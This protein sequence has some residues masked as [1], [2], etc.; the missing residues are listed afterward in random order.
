MVQRSSNLKTQK[1]DFFEKRPPPLNLI[2]GTKPELNP[3]IFCI[4]YKRFSVDF[5]VFVLNLRSE[6]ENIKNDQFMEKIV[7]L[8]KKNIENVQKFQDFLHIH[9]KGMI[10]IHL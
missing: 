5:C 7:H 6:E 1:N 9:E 2:N 4:R 10:L 3:E 8:T